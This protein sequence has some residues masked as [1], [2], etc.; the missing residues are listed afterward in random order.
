[1][2]SAGEPEGFKSPHT[3]E[4]DQYVLNG[5][6]QRVAGVQVAIRVYWRHYYCKGLSAAGWQIIRIK[7]TALFPELINPTFCFSWVVGF[8]KFHLLIKAE[9]RF[10][11]ERLPL[12]CSRILL[13]GEVSGQ[14]DHGRIVASIGEIWL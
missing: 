11:V 8:R 12:S 5:H 9:I 3:L 14:G 6:D 13:I 4:S 2:V 10:H 7:K 1:M